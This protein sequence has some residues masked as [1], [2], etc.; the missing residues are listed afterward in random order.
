MLSM[1]MGPKQYKCLSKL[2]V[3][4]EQRC[5]S[6]RKVTS[7]HLTGKKLAKHLNQISTCEGIFLIQIILQMTFIIKIPVHIA[8][9]NMFHVNLITV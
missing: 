3:F 6:C 7:N 5:F 1:C 4:N 9:N 8:Q 2:S